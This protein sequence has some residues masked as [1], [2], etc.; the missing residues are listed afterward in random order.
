ME[1]K[2]SIIVPIYNVEEYLEECIESLIN[3]T[4]TNI[5][6]VLVND[7]TKDNSGKICEKYAK[8]DPRIKY[9]IKKN[10]GLSSARNEG[11]KHI[12]GD[13][14]IFVD[15]DDYVSTKLCEII[16]KIIVEEKADLIQYEFKK[17]IDGE[18][19]VADKNNNTEIIGIYNHNNYYE[20]LLLVL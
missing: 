8:K 10:G 5:E 20:S 6:I 1:L 16:N 2:Y 18:E 17:F 12:T 7:G 11:L 4:Y 19:N 14:I 3:Q 15:S 9:I 13:Y